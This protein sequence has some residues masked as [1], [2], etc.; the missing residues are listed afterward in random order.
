MV[1]LE[2]SI[3]DT[4]HWSLRDIDETDIESLIP[5]VMEF[6]RWK[7]KQKAGGGRQKLYADEADG[8]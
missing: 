6:P 5:F 4:F 1:G 3:V 8:L 7:D 2:Y